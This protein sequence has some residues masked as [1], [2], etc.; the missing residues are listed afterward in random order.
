MRVRHSR[1]VSTPCSGLL[2]PLLRRQGETVQA[3]LHSNPIILE[4]AAIEGYRVGRLSQRQVAELLGFDFWQTESFLADRGVPL[5]CSCADIEADSATWTG[6][7]R[8]RERRP[9]F[10]V[11]PV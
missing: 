4:D 10:Q 8:A 2:D 1:H 7:S 3:G 6:V 5:D 11:R 9:G